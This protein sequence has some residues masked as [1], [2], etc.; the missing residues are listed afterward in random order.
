MNVGTKS[1]NASYYS[2]WLLHVRSCSHSSYDQKN[3]LGAARSLYRMNTKHLQ[4]KVLWDKLH[5]VW[6]PILATS[7][8]GI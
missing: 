3:E 8:D 2:S 1:F 6:V 4:E 7:T 5:D